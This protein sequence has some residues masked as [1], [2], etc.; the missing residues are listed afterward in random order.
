MELHRRNS[1]NENG[2]K[3]LGIQ[4]NKIVTHFVF[5]EG[6]FLDQ[7][8]TAHWH[9]AIFKQAPRSK[10]LHQSRAQHTHGETLCLMTQVK[11]TSEET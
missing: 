4:G 2:F 7:T 11:V 8:E 10:G 3:S 9:L 1:G 6:N 5:F